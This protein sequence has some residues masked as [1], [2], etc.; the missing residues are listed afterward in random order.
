MD[1]RTKKTLRALREAFCSLRRELPLERVTVREL[2]ERAEVGKATFYLHYH[3]VYDLSTELQE[4][5]VRTIVDEFERPDDLLG[6]TKAFTRALFSSF[7]AHASEIDTLFGHG[8]EHA[9]IEIVEHELR[10]RFLKTNA[11]LAADKRF[12]ALLTYQVHGSHAAYMRYARGGDEKDRE[13]VIEVI[14][15]ASDAV[16]Q[17]W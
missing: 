3:S 6:N 14:A 13:L 16:A 10:E 11:S 17:L 7:I 15:E 5:L 1:L 8:K 12:N 9:L 2:C 4:Q